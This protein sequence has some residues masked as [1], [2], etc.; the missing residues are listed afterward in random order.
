ML[1][2][3]PSECLI[4]AQRM[5]WPTLPGG[6]RKDVTKEMTFHLRLKVSK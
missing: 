5:Q 1:L 3:R 6:I 2:Q 4:R